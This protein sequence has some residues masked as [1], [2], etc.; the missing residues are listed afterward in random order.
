MG[1]INALGI[2]YI[3]GDKGKYNNKIEDKSVGYG[4]NSALNFSKYNKQ[5]SVKQI[6]KD[7]LDF[8]NAANMSDEEFDAKMKAANSG[9]RSKNPP[10]NFV[11]KYLPEKNVD[12]DNINK[13]ALLGAAFEEMGKKV[14]VSVADF[15]KLLQGAFGGDCTAEAFDINK[16]NQIDI[17]EYSTSILMSDML[18]ADDGKLDANN[19]TGEIK[20][21]GL[22]TL[23]AYTTQKNIDI[24]SDIVT[25]IHEHFELNQAKEDFISNP[26]NLIK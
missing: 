22:N 6:T 24:V 17:G 2:A 20:N 12:P 9:L 4:R 1:Y 23:P 5:F 15:T 7:T 8:S 3:T 18:S 16:D 13:M 10:L 19:I 26:N 21:K 25:S 14:S 11:Y